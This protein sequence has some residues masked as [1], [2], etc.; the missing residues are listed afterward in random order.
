MSSE[1]ISASKL[2]NYVFKCKIWG[3]WIITW[4]SS[5]PFITTFHLCP[6]REG[7]GERKAHNTCRQTRL[8][9]LSKY[10]SSLKTSDSST[11]CKY[12]Q[13]GQPQR[14]SWVVDV[15][16]DADYPAHACYGRYSKDVSFLPHSSKKS[17][18]LLS[19]YYVL[20]CS[21]SLVL[22]AS[23]WNRFYFTEETWEEKSWKWKSQ[24]L[25]S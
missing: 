14:L 8:C 12:Q 22:T 13:L 1:F 15:V 10:S 11:P 23:P 16:T 24:S 19:P 20:R 6:F 17:W 2:L 4:I 21:K 9:D 3:N 25:K 18:C 5:K 7:R